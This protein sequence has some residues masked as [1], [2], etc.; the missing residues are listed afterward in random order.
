M[1]PTDLLEL[2]KHLQFLFATAHKA[3]AGSG[4]HDAMFEIDALVGVANE[5]VRRKIRSLEIER[6]RAFRSKSNALDAAD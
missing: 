1:K 4:H 3:I 6:N 5:E 2:L